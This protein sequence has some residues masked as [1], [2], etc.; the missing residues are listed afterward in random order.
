LDLVKQ[1]IE[2]TISENEI[3]KSKASLIK[4]PKLTKENKEKATNKI[5][6]ELMEFIEKAFREVRKDWEEEKKSRENKILELEK[7]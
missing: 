2:I 7:E 4:D 3:D 6:G 1:G 5:V